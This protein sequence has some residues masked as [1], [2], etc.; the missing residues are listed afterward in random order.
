[1]QIVLD[2][3]PNLKQCVVCKNKGY[4]YILTP[5]GAAL[6]CRY[7]YEQD[8]HLDVSHAKRKT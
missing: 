5:A 3:H 6:L 7:H 2:K 4:R 1:M 8:K